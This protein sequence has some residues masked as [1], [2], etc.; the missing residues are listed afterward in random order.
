M[1][2]WS[3]L[4]IIVLIGKGFVNATGTEP[5]SLREVMRGLAK[6]VNSLNYGIFYEDFKMIEKSALEIAN[7]PKPLKQLPVVVKY[8]GKRVPKFKKFDLRVHNSS[9]ELA[10]LAKEKNLP[11][12]MKKHAVIMKNCVACHTQFR[13]EISKIF[14]Y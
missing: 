4:I 8:L 6:S 14:K 12:I 5:P 2:K 7:H 13:G 11:E 10:L 9:K 1:K 3:L